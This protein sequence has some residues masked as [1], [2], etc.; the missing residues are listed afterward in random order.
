MIEI[1]Y[2]KKISDINCNDDMIDEALEM[3]ILKETIST[4]KDI[5]YK[6]ILRKF[7]N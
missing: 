4:H 7:L 6:S 5:K 1:K 3:L 2:L